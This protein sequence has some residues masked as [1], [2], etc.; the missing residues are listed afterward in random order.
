LSGA[1]LALSFPKFGHPAFGWVSLAP[2]LVALGDLARGAGPSRPGAPP[3]LRRALALGFVTGAVF[4]T[5]TLYWL[6]QVMITFGGLH[7]AAATAVAALLIAYLS[8]YPALFAL[9]TAAVCRRWGT[10]ALLVAPAT[11]VTSELGRTYVGSGFPWVLLGYSQATALPVAQ[12]ASVAG[13]FGLSLIVAAVGSSMA[14]AFHARGRRR[15]AA[16]IAAVAVVLATAG[17]GAWRMR[18]GVLLGEGTPIR[19]ALVQGNIPQDDKWNPALRGAIFDRYVAMSRRALGARAE[20]VIWPES[21]TPFYFELDPDGRALRRLVAESGVPFLVGSDQVEPVQRIPEG[22]RDG[23]PRDGSP[24]GPR[25]YNAAF[26]IGPDGRTA[27]VYRKM[28]LVPFGEYVPLKRLLFFVAPLVE[29][30]GDFSPGDVPTTLPVADHPASVAI[31]Y[32]VIYPSLIRGFVANGSELLTTITNDAWYGWSSAAYQHW[33]QASLR[34]IEEGRYLARAANTGISGFVDPYGRVLAASPMFEPAVL[35]RDL[36]FIRART[37]YSR[38][39]DLAAWLCLA[40]TA[41]ALILAR[42]Q[43][44]ESGIQKGTG[45]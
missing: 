18:A 10:R 27:A 16:P 11:W 7:A 1:L 20:F 2:L 32:E 35:V 41:A 6:V 24:E 5:G 34:A 26:L 17:W 30:V 44:P 8:L 22:Q 42:I 43:N 38:I 14:Y 9:V 31:C 33:E 13:V 29:A 28:H 21:A 40:A 15:L 45:T 36:R 37:V 3:A 39:G 23:K 4:F 19:V 12:A 25:Y